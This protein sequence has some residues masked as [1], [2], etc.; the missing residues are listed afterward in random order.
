M[1]N[2]TKIISEYGLK[3]KYS[4]HNL[5]AIFYCLQY[6]GNGTVIEEMEFPLFKKLVKLRIPILFIITH[7]PYNPYKENMK[8]EAKKE[9]SEDIKRIENT[10][11]EKIKNI[12][13]KNSEEYIENFVRFYYVNLVGKYDTPI[14]G[15][16]ELLSYF[17]KL[18]SEE[19]WNNLE[20]SCIERNEN[21]C[22]KYCEKNPFLKN[23]LILKI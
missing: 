7:F 18:V 6:K 16:N 4:P 21:E 8:K 13:K 15:L 23:I 22:K 14:F 20:K 2:Y 11:K 12:R 10:I 17:T 1:E 9:I 5:N 3:S 19:D